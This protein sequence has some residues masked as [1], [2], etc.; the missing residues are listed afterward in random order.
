MAISVAQRFD[1]SF[2][3][4]MIRDFFLVLLGVILIEL[5]IRFALVIYDFNTEQKIVTQ[6]TAERLATDVQSIMLNRGGAV[7]A[8]TV[9]P[10]LH[11][12]HDRLGF[13]VSIQPS[14]I[15]IE[16]IQSVFNFT[17]Q[18]IPPKWPEGRYQEARVAIRA[19]QFCVQCHVTAKPG[20]VLGEVTVRGYLDRQL[21]DWWHEVKLTGTLGMAKILLHTIVLFLLLKIRMEPLVSLRAVIALLAKAGSDLS[22]RAPIRSHDEFGEL[23]RDL[24]LFLDRLCQI[25]EDL[26]GVITRVMDINGRLITVHDQMAGH[27]RDV[28]SKALEIVTQTHYGV[29]IDPVLSEEW[30]SSVDGLL[31]SLQKIERTEGVTTEQSQAI[32]KLIAP[33][34]RLAT[35]AGEAF[36]QQTRIGLDLTGLSIK[37]RDFSRWLE[38]MAVLEEKMRTISEQGQTLL[39]RLTDQQGGEESNVDLKISSR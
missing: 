3:I 27:Y 21:Q 30:L 20:D 35:G 23:A 31:A 24:N 37:V 39:Q 34:K 2:S 19:E 8:R 18:G 15:T 17:P 7:A 14:A 28:D 32:R 5:G 36:D 38:E 12:N 4:H 11:R 10:I 22:H 6:R 13:S 26:G 25:V 33:L 1:D 16:S 29:R 9:Y